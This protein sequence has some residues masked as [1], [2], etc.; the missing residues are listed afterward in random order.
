MYPPNWPKCP[1]CGGDAL[2][3]KV[4]C[5]RAACQDR[6]QRVQRL[7]RRTCLAYRDDG[8]LCGEPATTVD[9]V[10]MIVV[11]PEHAPQERS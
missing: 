1:V 9:P 3:G 5:G 7:E 10:Q 4:T 8:R 6:V 11:C 2:D